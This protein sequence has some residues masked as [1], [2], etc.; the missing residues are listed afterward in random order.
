MT[1]FVFESPVGPLFTEVT[2]EG[3][4]RVDLLA[5]SRNLSRRSEGGFVPSPIDDVEEAPRDHEGERAIL[6][7]LATQIEEYFDGSRLDFDL[8]LDIDTGSIFQRRIW[9]TI[10]TTPDRSVDSCA[11]AAAASAYE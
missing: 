11:W 2:S 1:A 5:P 10:A 4:R 6:E 7:A 8:P 9:Q 3:V